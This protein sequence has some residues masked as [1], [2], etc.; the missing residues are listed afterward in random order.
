[1]L[2]DFENDMAVLDE[3]TV[4]DKALEEEPNLVYNTELTENELINNIKVDK[5]YLFSKD[6]TRLIINNYDDLII[7]TD[8]LNYLVEN[9]T[10]Y[11]VVPDY[12]Y[13]NSFLF[14]DEGS[15]ITDDLI[16]K[17]LNNKNSLL[18]DYYFKHL[19]ESPIE[20]DYVNKISSVFKIN[21]DLRPGDLRTYYAPG[22]QA[23]LQG[24]TIENIEQY[25]IDAQE[26]FKTMGNT[27]FIND[28]YN[29]FII[30]ALQTK[31]KEMP[32]KSYA[33]LSRAVGFINKHPNLR[34]NRLSR[35][36]VTS[37]ELLTPKDEYY[38]YDEDILYD[39]QEYVEDI[40]QNDSI[41]DYNLIY[42][43]SYFDKKIDFRKSLN[44]IINI[45][46]GTSTISISRAKYEKIQER[47]INESLNYLEWLLL[48]HHNDT[49]TEEFEATL[50]DFI[51]YNWHVFANNN[52]SFI[53]LKCMLRNYSNLEHLIE[54]V[55]IGQKSGV[56]DFFGGFS[57]FAVSLLVTLTVFASLCYFGIRFLSSY[58]LQIRSDDALLMII[59]VEVVIAAGLTIFL[60]AERE[61]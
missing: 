47:T 33:D 10:E 57:P 7:K 4:L 11:I 28:L 61:T 21:P 49:K 6:A 18:F 3:T 17:V 60:V 30:P 46:E 58:L 36:L 34:Y 5:N 52:K 31:I 38:S 12:T 22:L 14:P 27:L 43:C 23:Y 1:L 20:Q 9:L 15:S 50:K 56:G 8:F 59:L 35:I 45:L 53:N 41:L 37:Y 54:E 29:K 25:V 26:S 55:K 40:I 2:K 24:L 13:I 32:I 51:S 48:N 19:F 16:K 39:V 44:L 42:L